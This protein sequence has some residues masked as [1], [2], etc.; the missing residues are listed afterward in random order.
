MYLIKIFFHVVYHLLYISWHKRYITTTYTLYAHELT[1]DSCRFTGGWGF[2]GA[3]R[4]AGILLLLAFPWGPGQGR[5]LGLLSGSL[6]LW[7]WILVFWVIIL[8]GE[9]NNDT[10]IVETI[11]DI[12]KTMFVQ[13]IKKEKTYIHWHYSNTC[14][15]IYSKILVCSN[16]KKK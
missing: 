13:R 7:L 10:P 12:G 2:L 4:F 1:C 9:E 8:H 14:Y 15:I 6:L 11:I 5:G 3:G 16:K